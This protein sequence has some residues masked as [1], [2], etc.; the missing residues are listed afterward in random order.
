MSLPSDRKSLKKVKR[1]KKALQRSKKKPD[2]RL[3]LDIETDIYMSGTIHRELQPPHCRILSPDA[4]RKCFE[5]YRAPCTRFC[6]AKVYEE[7]LDANGRFEGIH[8]SFTNCVH[9][10][11][12][13]IKDPFSNIEWHPPEGGDGPR[14]KNM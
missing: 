3:Y 10:K 2:N 6:P 4:C 13:E 14:Y 1:V 5:E 9:C 7:K 11:T 8:V 12:C